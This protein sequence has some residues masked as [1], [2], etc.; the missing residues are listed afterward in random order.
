MSSIVDGKKNV[1]GQIAAYK[2]MTQGLPS[3][4]LSSSMPSIN[5][6]G[7]IVSFLVDLIT[8]LIGYEEF[9]NAIINIV[10][11]TLPMLERVV[12]QALM[13]ELKNIVSCGVNPSLPTWIK[14]TGAGIVIPVNKIDL[15]DILRTNP[16]S[17]GGQFIYSDT[18][19]PLSSTDFNTFLYAVIQNDGTT[20]TWR[21]IFDITFNSIGIGGN[22][23]NTLTIKA[24][25]SYDSKT[26]TDLNNDFV[27]SLTLF[28][29]ENILNQVM[30]IIYGTVS[31][32]IGKSLKQLEKEAQIYTVVEKMVNNVNTNQLND[33]Q[34]TF[35]NA[36][37]LAHQ[38]TASARK[39][40]LAVITTSASV[41]TSV[42]AST[43]TNFN[44]DFALA[45]SSSQK[46]S[47]LGAHLDIMANASVANITNPIDVATGKSNFIKQIILS[48]VKSFVN[49]ILSPKVIFIFLI[50]YLIVY[51]PTATYDDPIDFIKKNKRLMN[52]III[53]ISEAIVKVL[54]GIALK[55]IGTL[56]AQAI[57]KKEQE[58]G[59]LTLAQLES[60][61]GIPSNLVNNLLQS[62]I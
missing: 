2:T 5:N 45:T 32:T 56:V 60:L 25:P 49:V 18:S 53:A 29:T 55:E 26:L 48:L 16:N 30:D 59:A 24:H 4:K 37:T 1:F 20:E 15:L 51:G 44:A 40:G 58:K 42:P 35:T 8:Q 3:L 31:S 12:K 61:I 33:S 22:P 47:T 57:A 14:S 62:L 23:N 10:L 46:R 21:G 28:K 9:V 54:L 43:L 36:E 39:S 17:V 50:N 52:A 7:D 11:T 38:Q 13:V 41:T 34:F 6:S 19:I 27:N